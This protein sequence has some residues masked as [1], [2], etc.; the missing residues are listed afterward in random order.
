MADLS[1]SNISPANGH[2]KAHFALYA[3]KI[4]SSNRTLTE[5]FINSR[6]RR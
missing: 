3:D 1:I 5:I 2:R 4:A 6:L